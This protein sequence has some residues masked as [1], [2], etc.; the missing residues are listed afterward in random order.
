M[1]HRGFERRLVLGAVVLLATGLFALL[2]ACKRDAKADASASASAR[3]PQTVPSASAPLKSAGPALPE[4]PQKV[5]HKDSAMGTT[6]HFIVYTTEQV[7]RART[8][9]AIDAAISEMRRLEAILSEW[10]D[11]SEVGRINLQAGQ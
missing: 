3:Q 11:D 6:L 9:A 8:E 10:R 2:P 7:D 1:F 5:E 4:E